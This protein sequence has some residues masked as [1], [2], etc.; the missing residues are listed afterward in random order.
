M[1]APEAPPESAAPARRVGSYDA[2]PAGISLLALIAEDFATHDRRLLEPGFWAIAVHRF[3]NWRKGIKP[4]ILELP[5][6]LLYRG[7]YI[8]T[9]WLWGIDLSYTVKLGRRVRIWHHGGIVL[10]P[11]SIG[12]DVHIR[13]NTTMGL[14]NR[15]DD[16][17]ATPTIEDRVD[18]GVGA[19]ILGRLTIGHDSV[20]GANTVV[21]KDV[22]PNSTVFGIPA[23]P[24]RLFRSDTQRDAP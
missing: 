6:S 23:R 14:L 17:T 19:C 21:V 15:L 7:L 2:N 16:D 8:G 9:N 10:G 24:V 18:I 5:F 1:D 20:I 3:G 22:P 12:D 13:Q 4:R 11:R